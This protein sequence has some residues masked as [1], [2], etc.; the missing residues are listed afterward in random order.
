MQMIIWIVAKDPG[1]K[2]TRYVIRFRF[3]IHITVRCP[4]S[5]VRISTNSTHART[6]RCRATKFDMTGSWNDL[7]EN[8]L[9]SLP[10]LKCVLLCKRHW[11]RFPYSSRSGCGKGK[12]KPSVVGWSQKGHQTPSFQRGNRLTQV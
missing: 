6:I 4:R 5:D 10:T 7:E 3:Y 12:G 9:C 2:I 11:C 1:H 8:F